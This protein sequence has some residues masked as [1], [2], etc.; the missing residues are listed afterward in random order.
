MLNK[1]SEDLVGPAMA[2]ASNRGNKI[3]WNQLV[4]LH[5]HL[6]LEREGGRERGREEGREGKREGEREGK[7]KG[8]KEGGWEGGWEEGRE[9]ERASTQNKH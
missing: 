8:G 7:R 1:L 5:P 3:G 4:V 2:Q 6:H 9:E